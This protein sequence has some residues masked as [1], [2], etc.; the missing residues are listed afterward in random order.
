MFLAV[1]D[2]LAISKQTN[3]LY[4]LMMDIIQAVGNT[5][6]WAFVGLIIL[7][8]ATRLFDL[9]TPVNYQSEI[10]QGNV[11]AAIL[12]ASVVLSL[13]AIVVAVMVT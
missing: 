11:A 8:A 3:N 2:R 7:Y 4:Q 10:R 1:L 12:V 5:I 9:I 13:A 6:G